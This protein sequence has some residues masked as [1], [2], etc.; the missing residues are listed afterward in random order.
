MPKRK[1]RM[2]KRPL[3]KRRKVVKKVKFRKQLALK[4]HTFVERCTPLILNLNNAALTADGNF[5][6]T[7]TF[8]YSLDQV[9]QMTSYQKL[10]EY[11]KILKVVVNFK[12]KTIGNYANTDPTIGNPVNEINPTLIFK[13]DHNDDTADTI[14]TMLESVR[15]KEKQLTNNNPSFSIVLKPAIQSMLYKTSASTAYT[16]SWN[17]W[18]GMISPGIPHYGLKLQVQTPPRNVNAD[19][20]SIWMTTKIYFA[21]KNNE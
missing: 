16:P 13:V 18:L 20:G 5:A 12:Y 14:G 2:T 15:T 9:P 1:S 8:V 11:Y 17:N 4:S 19:Y 6:T 3:K 10:F 21:C 7:K